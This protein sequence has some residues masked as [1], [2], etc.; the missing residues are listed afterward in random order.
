MYK[1]EDNCKNCSSRVLETFSTNLSKSEHDSFIDLIS[2]KND[3]NINAVICY[4]YTCASISFPRDEESMPAF[5]YSMI[6]A[7][8]TN[9]GLF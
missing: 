9:G 2:K 3:T 1:K 8:P 7:L 6:A 4:C 5:K